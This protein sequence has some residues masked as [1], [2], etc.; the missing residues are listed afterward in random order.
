VANTIKPKRSYTASATPTLA[1][2]ELAIQ[3]ADKK[4]FIGNSGGT[5]NI[6]VASLNGSDIT[7]TV[8]SATSATTA[9]SATSA[10]TAT[11]LA[12]GGAGQLPYQS[13]SGT[14]AMLAA[15]TS[16]QVLRS[17]GSSA[18]SWETQGFFSSGRLTLE[19]NVP[20]STAGQTSKTAVYFTPYNGDK[21][22]IYNGT[23]WATYT[24]SQLTLNLGTLTSGKNYDVFIYNNSG[25]LTLE[26]SAAWTSDT[27]RSEALTLTNGIYVKSSANTR[28]YLGTIR[29][30]STTTTEDSASKRFVWNYNNRVN[31]RMFKQ[32]AAS[33]W[34]YATLNTYRYL[35]NNSA[36]SLAF[37]NGIMED[38]I[39]VMAS[40]VSSGSG[41][42]R[43]LAIG[44]DSEWSTSSAGNGTSEYQATGVQAEASN[45]SYQSFA[46]RIPGLGYHVAYVL[47]LQN[48]TTTVTYYGGTGAGITANWRY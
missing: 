12:G 30:T 9:T 48:S 14:T 1:A 22:S 47:E 23:T 32:Y 11:N 28:R 39:F 26:L 19:S 18:P 8:A 3:A 15:G 25:T 4:V 41:I 13:A 31:C 5:G 45:E 29:T 17:N 40:A 43:E 10:T 37:I 33:T 42:Q 24:F 21:I 44:F 16:G 38:N 34:T 36:N 35:G 27:A 7:G 20:V 2:G 46:N 6:L